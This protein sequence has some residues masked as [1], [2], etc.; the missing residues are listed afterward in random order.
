LELTRDE[1]GRV[2]AHRAL[3]DLTVGAPI[4]RTL[5]AIYFDTPNHRLHA[6]GISF[7][8]HSEGSGWVQRVVRVVDGDGQLGGDTTVERPEPN[9]SAI[10]S[11]AMR[12]QVAKAIARP[13]LAPVFETIVQRTTRRL[14]A[15]EGESQLALDEGVM[16]AGGR[17]DAV[18]EAELE[19]KSGNPLTLLETAAKLF[20]GGPVT[21]RRQ[22][23]GG[24]RRHAGASPQQQRRRDAARRAARHSEANRCAARR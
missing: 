22:Q 20:A 12:K 9:V 11:R 23:Q 8:M 3:R 2:R 4:T 14:H 16:R 18:I 21:P 7:F 6:S 10:V 15:A 17:E 5:R 19:L 13:V 1:L 24:T